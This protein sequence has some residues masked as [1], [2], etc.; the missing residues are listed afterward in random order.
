MYFETTDKWWP[1][2]F[3]F[4]KKLF[5]CLCWVLVAA[6][7]I[8]SLH[9]GM[10]ILSLWHVGSSSPTRDQTQAP[11]IGAQSLSYWTTKKVSRFHLLMNALES[12]RRAYGLGNVLLLPLKKKNT[13]IQIC[14]LTTAI[15]FPP[16]CKI[17][18]SK[19]S[20]SFMPL[21]DQAQ[22]HDPGPG[23]DEAPWIQ[24]CG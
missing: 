20:Q 3:F 22:H 5:I 4:W 8:F 17:Y 13:I 9:C 19:T 7:G 6:L 10:Q 18:P 15:C 1:L 12:S 16:A 23:T 21:Q 11:C 14:S 2:S 24:W